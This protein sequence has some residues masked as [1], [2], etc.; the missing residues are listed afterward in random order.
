MKVESL[1]G[2]VELPETL[3]MTEFIRQHSDDEIKEAAGKMYERL[4]NRSPNVVIVDSPEQLHE[5]A[6]K[7]DPNDNLRLVVDLYPVY[8]NVDIRLTLL[9][10]KVGIKSNVVNFPKSTED[11][12]NE[13]YAFLKCFWSYISMKGHCV[14]CRNPIKV[15]VDKHLNGIV[16]ITNPMFKVS[17]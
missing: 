17:S 13:M 9:R 16:R 12:L 6:S 1:F 8:D 10:A 11:N 3:L 14:V 5:A 4:G 15:T 2:D 7:L